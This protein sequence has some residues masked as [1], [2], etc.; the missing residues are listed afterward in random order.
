MSTLLPLSLTAVW[1]VTIIHL[2]GIAGGVFVAIGSVISIANMRVAWVAWLLVMALGVPVMFGLSI[3]GVWWIYFSEAA[4]YFTYAVA[5]PWVFLIA[6]V[7]AMVASF[8]F[9]T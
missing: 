8:R 5:F 6:F 1:I 3:I 7:G 2:L 9:V 4:G